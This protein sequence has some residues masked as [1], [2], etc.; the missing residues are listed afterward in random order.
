L[1]I[2]LNHG[3]QVKFSRQGKTKS[4]S[5]FMNGLINS[6]HNLCEINIEKLS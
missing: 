6:K 3:N 2:H 1:N 5:K 4:P